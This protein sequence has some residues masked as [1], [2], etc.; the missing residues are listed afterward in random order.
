M[1]IVLFLQFFL[2]ILSPEL[3]RGGEQLSSSCASIIKIYPVPNIS[4]SWQ[5]NAG[6]DLGIS[7]I[8]PEFSVSGYLAQIFSDIRYYFQ[9]EH[10]IK[11]AWS[12]TGPALGGCCIQISGYFADFYHPYVSII[13]HYPDIR[14]L[15][16]EF[17]GRPD[18]GIAV[19]GYLDISRVILKKRTRSRS[20]GIRISGNFQDF[21]STGLHISISGIISISFAKHFR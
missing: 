20:T 10:F 13:S 9:A 4:G 21:S 19:P 17:S 18:L 16:S 3:S 5:S 12:N 8:F 7:G 1:Y 15:F 14:D 2:K 6:P 11:L